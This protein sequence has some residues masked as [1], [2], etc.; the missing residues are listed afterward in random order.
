MD[1]AEHDYHLGPV[2]DKAVKRLL[3]RAG[4]RDDVVME[5]FLRGEEP[6]WWRDAATWEHDWRF[7]F[8]DDDVGPWPWDRRLERQRQFDA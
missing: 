6:P 2:G 1:C 7:A 5:P 4:S 8:I 3:C